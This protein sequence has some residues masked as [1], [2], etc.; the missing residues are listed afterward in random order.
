MNAPP[1]TKLGSELIGKIRFFI[2]DQS[3]FFIDRFLF[4]WFVPTP[5]IERIVSFAFPAGE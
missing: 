3:Q 5:D 1:Q 4:E 2:T